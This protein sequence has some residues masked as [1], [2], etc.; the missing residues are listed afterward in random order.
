MYKRQIL[1]GLFTAAVE[2]TEE[3]VLSALW[4]AATTTGREGRVAEALPHVV[5]LELLRS[6]GRLGG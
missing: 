4:T 6:H 1:D 2:A 5:V 3:A